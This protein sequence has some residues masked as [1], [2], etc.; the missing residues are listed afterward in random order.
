MLLANDIDPL[1]RSSRGGPIVA[2]LAAYISLMSENTG[3]VDK[4][5]QPP[6]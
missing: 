4:D 5:R 1:K 3:L 2:G 6:H